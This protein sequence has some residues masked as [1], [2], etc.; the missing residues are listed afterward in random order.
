VFVTVLGFVLQG[1]PDAQ[2]SI[3][4]SV[5]GQFP[6]IGQRIHPGSLH[7]S[8]T[9]LAIG[10]VTSLLSGLGVTSAIQNAL[11]RLWAVPLKDRPNFLHARL[12]GLALLVLIGGMFVISTGVSGA[13]AGGLGG[14]A[15]TIGG[16]VVSL[17]LDFALFGVTFRL[18]TPAIV[19]TRDLL[20]GV[21]VA[22]CFWEILQAVGGYY[23]GHVL[24]HTQSDLADFS[25]VI[26]L[27]L[28]L[29]LGAQMTLYAAEINVVV[30]RRLW[31]R[32]F[33]SSPEVP[34]DE[35]ALE[36]LAKVEER[37]ERQHIEVGFEEPGAED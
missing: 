30:S 4:H 23:I 29:H 33:F 12:R 7:G 1:N 3:E 15:A 17:L 31:P 18:M 2:R 25:L 20:I 19:R 5:L 13:V 11:D 26:G 27:L 37:S 16:I 21:V 36:A 9:A 35:R 14:P 24:K 6:I 34:A 22:G 8:A 32:S 28:F 10:I